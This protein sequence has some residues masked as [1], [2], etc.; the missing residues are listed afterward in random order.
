MKKTLPYVLTLFVI[1]GAVTPTFAVNID[2]NDQTVGV[3]D[4]L[5]NG[6]QFSAGDPALLLDTLVES[7]VMGENYLMNG[8]EGSNTTDEYVI[9]ASAVGFLFNMFSVDL[10][11]YDALP[12]GS[13]FQI[14]GYNGAT[15]VAS[16]SI[17]IADFNYHD[18]DIGYASGFDRVRISGG[19]VPFFQ[20]DNVEFTKYSSGT[21]PIPEPST[22]IL[23]AAGLVGVGFNRIRKRFAWN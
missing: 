20:I 14:E 17:T 21:E 12:G 16:D 11:T 2:F 10:L 1:I 8:R 23:I 9:F 6:V 18:L 5:I 7:D 15:L 3:T 4:P 22:M 13:E 19:L